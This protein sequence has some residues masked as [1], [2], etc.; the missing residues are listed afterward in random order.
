MEVLT[1][2]VGD[3]VEL[4]YQSPDDTQQG[5]T[6]RAPTLVLVEELKKG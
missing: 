2:Q 5:S 1:L 4:R 6:Q 3:T